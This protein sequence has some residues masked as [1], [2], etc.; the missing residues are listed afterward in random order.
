VAWLAGQPRFTPALIEEAAQ[1][2]DLS[3]LDAAILYRWFSP[4]VKD[5][6][7]Q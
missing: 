5:N 6:S 4:A 2:F 7:D 1:R 3:P